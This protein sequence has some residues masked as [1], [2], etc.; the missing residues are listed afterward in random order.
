CRLVDA[1]EARLTGTLSTGE[2]ALVVGLESTGVPLDEHAA[3][4]TALLADHGLRCVEAGPRGP[5]GT[6]W[7][8][9]FVRAPYVRELLV[10]LGVI[11]E[12]FE[13]AVT[14]DRFHQL[15]GA[16]P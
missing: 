10:M 2:H 6:A 7:R 8:S 4:A 15:F 9:A 12:T 14:W 16:V 3:A 5:A 13:T 1:R 11:V